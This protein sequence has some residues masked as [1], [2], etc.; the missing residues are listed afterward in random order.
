MASPA[1]SIG[2]NENAKSASYREFRG[3]QDGGG[4]IIFGQQL[5]P[6]WAEYCWWL[7]K[8]AKS[9]PATSVTRG[10][11]AVVTKCEV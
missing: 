1:P 11:L 5:V 6:L 9:Q 7:V 3:L 2:S 4:F 10:P 8:N